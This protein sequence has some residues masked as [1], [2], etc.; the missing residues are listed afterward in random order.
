M[1]KCPTSIFHLHKSQHFYMKKRLLL[2]YIG[3]IFCVT[4]FWTAT[5]AA[6]QMATIYNN[7]WIDYSRT[8]FKIKVVEE[9]LH[10]IPYNTL[11]QF[12]VALDGNSLKMYHNGQEIPL[13][14]ST[15][16]TLS[17]GDY[18]RFYGEKNDGILDRQ[19]FPRPEWQLQDKTSLFSDTAVYYLTWFPD[20]HDGLRWQEAANDISNPP[21]KEQYFIHTKLEPYVNAYGGGVSFRQLGGSDNYLGD[22]GNGEGFTSATID[23][24]YAKDFLVSTPSVYTNA[25]N[26]TIETRII[27]QSDNALLIYDH[28]IHVK[29]NDEI[30][31]DTTYEGRENITFTFDIPI[32]ELNVD[33]TTKVTVH[34]LQDISSSDR[35]SV[36]Y[37]KVTYPHTYDFEGTRNFRFQLPQTSND[38]YIEVSNF[39]GG[40]QPILYDLSNNIFTRPIVD[41]STGQAVYRFMLKGLGG[42]SVRDLVLSNTS[43]LGAVKIVQQVKTA[44]F[45]DFSAMQKQGNYIILTHPKLRRGD[46]DEVQRYED[47]RISESGGNYTVAT[48]NVEE[49]YDQFAWGIGKHPL[50]IRNFVNYAVDTWDIAPEY[51]LLLGKGIGYDNT[52]N[53]S[54]QYRKCLV[55][56]YGQT[57]SDMLLSA[58]DVFTNVSQLATGRVPAQKPAHIKAYLDKVI[59]YESVD[60]TT[61]CTKEDRKWTKD[62]LHIA[63]G[64]SITEANIFANHLRGY[65][66]IIKEPPF[67]GRVVAE[68]T[69]ANDATSVVIPELEQVINNGVSVITFVGHGA[70][71]KWSVELDRPSAY[72]NYGKYPFMISSSCHV[73][74]IHLNNTNEEEEESMAIAYILEPGLG[75]IGFLATVS[76]GYPAFMDIYVTQTYKEFSTNNY[77]KPIGYALRE[78]GRILDEN[79]PSSGADDNY[80]NGEI[81]FTTQEY[82]LIGDPAIVLGYW[83]KPEYLL[84]YLSPTNVTANEDSIAIKFVISNLG[85]GVRDSFTVNIDRTY[86]DNST[87]TVKSERFPAT[88]YVDTMTLYVP[89]GDISEVEGEN[90]FTIT[91][92]AENEI[93]EDCEDNNRISSNVFVFSDLLIPVSPCDFSIV[94]EPEITLYTSTGE[95]N[96]TSKPYVIQVD[97]TE[98]FDS[99]LLMQQ[100]MNSKGGIVEWTPEMNWIDN[101]VYYWRA[102]Q[103]PIN[104]AFYNWQGSSFIYKKNSESGWNQSHYYQF[105]KDEL[106]SIIIDSS[107]R[108]FEYVGGLNT[109]KIR[110]SYES[111]DSISVFE[112]ILNVVGGTCLLHNGCRGGLSFVA[113][114]ARDELTP[115]FTSKVVEQPGQCDDR[116]TYGNFQCAGGTKRGIE[117]YTANVEQVESMLA[118][119]RDTIPDGYYIIAYSVNNHRLGTTDP[120]DPIYPYLAEIQ[121][122]FTSELDAPQIASLRNDEPFILFGRKG[123]YSFPT[124]FKTFDGP[125]EET[126]EVEIDVVGKST[127]GTIYSPVI[128]PSHQWES[129]NWNYESLEDEINDKDNF[130]IGVYGINGTE[131]ELLLETD[132]NSPYDLSSID[133]ATYPYIRLKAFTNDTANF[134]TPQLKHWRVHYDLAAEVAINSKEQLVLT[135]DTVQEGELIQ[136]DLAV[137]NIGNAD[138]DSLLVQYTIIDQNGVSHPITTPRQAPISVGETISTHFE[139]STLGF[140]GSNTLV[141]ELNPKNPET[142]KADQLE[143]FKFN[144]LLFLPFYVSKDRINPYIDV[145]FD[146]KHILDGQLISA[147][148]KILIRLKDENKYLPLNNPDDVRIILKQPDGNEEFID[149]KNSEIAIFTPAKS[150]DAS[151]GNNQ[152]TVELA[153]DFSTQDGVYTLIIEAADRSD[154]DFA[155]R[156]YKISF[157]V[158]NKPMISNVLNYPNPFTTSTSF[159]FTLTGSEIPEHLKI[160]IMTVSGKVVREISSAELGDLQIGE[161]ITEFQWDGTDQYGNELGNGVYL[162]KVSARLN[163]I[164]LERY[165][166]V[167]VDANFKN[168]IG[169][170]YLMR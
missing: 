22:F 56:S 91:I 21:A 161:N 11:A 34:S 94:S 37:V 145:T 84:D 66:K 90:T 126:F 154:N 150:S 46:V 20:K 59:E 106:N 149:L 49:L 79:Y 92:D 80:K 43:D 71:G 131:E 144:N 76:F 119:L 31:A 157:E 139:Y 39:I 14:I 140:A 121:D 127:E 114:D 151:E 26:A 29:V 44:S 2:L 98:N 95:A 132:G 153:P 47:Y 48:V 128:G 63:G 33:D 10:E 53:D 3:I 18:I 141:V 42:S 123:Q 57:A 133:A 62:V 138:L 54:V 111:L 136:L 72:E 88:I 130:S 170:M 93:E 109:I 8:Y 107:N 110:N 97:T 32:N 58:R 74:N 60:E 124:T 5:K 86:P 125:P 169:K 28:H 167:G 85:V 129:L 55:P 89:L 52:R 77:G 162:Y 134:T 1:S 120:S 102:S 164:P 81:R 73:G 65:G 24:T 148:P 64:Q 9:G 135:R 137:A 99:P 142:G 146:D 38:R 17:D 108:V 16:N 103:I 51:L 69:K 104:D 166:R 100:P 168:E 116:G 45:T 82:T 36:A 12:G 75:S 122:F 30:L 35:N 67:A 165:E 115:L 50:A 70:L 160:Q 152:A 118:F 68:Y 155:D 7:E 117:F 112:N 19:L 27:G 23:G 40:S 87:E 15:A 159:V 25:G 6:A 156:A 143:K 83:E 41:N 147:K 4:S 105:K 158:V 61:P 101:T 78:T 163:G 113:M 13:Q 96:A